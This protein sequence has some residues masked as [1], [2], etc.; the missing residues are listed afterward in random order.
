[1]A[2]TIH[3]FA[4]GPLVWTTFRSFPSFRS[5]SDSNKPPA[6]QMWWQAFSHVEGP[7]PVGILLLPWSLQL[8]PEKV[9]IYQYWNGSPPTLEV[10]PAPPPPPRISWSL[11]GDRRKCTARSYCTPCIHVFRAGH[12]NIFKVGYAMV[13]CKYF[14]FIGTGY[15]PIYVPYLLPRYI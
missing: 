8:P 2:V 4:L 5:L 6:K 15:I 9:H 3:F 10:T 13:Y 7:P 1:V 12:Y 11:E 14:S